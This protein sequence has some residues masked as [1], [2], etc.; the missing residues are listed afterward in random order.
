MSIRNV[1]VE[2]YESAY[3]MGSS[4]NASEQSQEQIHEYFSM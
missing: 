2:R 4:R 1:A 3:G